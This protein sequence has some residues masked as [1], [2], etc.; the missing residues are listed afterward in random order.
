M[1]DTSDS[2]TGNESSEVGNQQDR[3]S[4]LWGAFTSACSEDEYYRSWLTLQSESIVGA[5]Q[6]LLIVA[7]KSEQFAPVAR[8]PETGADSSLLSDVA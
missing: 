6:S 3:A 1:F 7:T 8:W 4:E 5:I 2:I